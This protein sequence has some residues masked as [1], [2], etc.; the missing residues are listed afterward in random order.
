MALET[1][2]F[3]RKLRNYK[4]ST[5]KIDKN[6]ASVL[7]NSVN[8]ISEFLNEATIQDNDEKANVI[9]VIPAIDNEIL[10]AHRSFYCKAC[11]LACKA[12]PKA[13]N[14]HFFGN[15]HL[16]NLRELEGSV[17]AQNKTKQR[18]RG[19]ANQNGEAQSTKSPKERSTSLSKTISVPND[20]LPKNYVQFL[21]LNH[22]LDTYTVF[23]LQDGLRL[24]NSPA[25]RQICELIRKRLS[26]RFPNVRA[27][28]FGS[29]VIG[30]GRPNGDLDIFVDVGNCYYE[31]PSKQ[32]MKD[33][34][35]QTM[36]VLQPKSNEW[37]E[38]EAV[39]HARTPILRV[40]CRAFNIDC[41]LSFSN[42]LSHCNTA[43][44]R[45]FIDLQPV[46]KKL[47][48]FVKDWVQQ[49]KLGINSYIVSL[50]VIFYLQQENLLPPVLFLQSCCSTPVIIDGWHA[51]FATLPNPITIATDFTKYLNGFFNYY[52]FTFDYEKYVISV[53]VGTP[54]EKSIFDHGK[55][56]SL[57]PAFARFANYMST[58]DLEEADEVED[59]FSNHKPLVI[60]DPFELCHNVAKGI[61]APKLKKI[62][63]YMRNTLE[64]LLQR[65]GV[66]LK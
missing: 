1:H 43:L 5:C 2:I 24:M 47:C 57:P 31:K 19:S 26:P 3:T 46:C 63:N 40:F 39:T 30:L 33:A 35:Y 56:A 38:Y 29:M 15:K 55:E 34:I 52:G 62:I 4:E 59:L 64:F 41:D 25:N 14:E 49:L 28:A 17:V 12:S 20:K 32:K 48:A 27:N 10:Q 60:Q 8:E 16:K 65:Q 61:Q 42:G 53:L 11:N 23:L 18:T 45:Y 54:V 9:D 58:I 51:N 7:L 37:G 22:D 66:V 36:R 44:I 6:L 50:L 13:F 21:T